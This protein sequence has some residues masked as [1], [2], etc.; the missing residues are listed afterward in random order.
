MERSEIVAAASLLADAYRLGQRLDALPQ[1]CQPTSVAEAHAIQD[2][3][4]GLLDEEVV[5]WKVAGTSADEVMRGALFASRVRPSPADFSAESVPLMGVE[6]EVAFRFRR[7]FPARA[8]GYRREE[9]AEGVDAFAAIEVVDTRFS[10]YSGTPPLHRL[11]DFMSNGG[12]VYGEPCPDWRLLDL[13]TIPVT[14][15]ADNVT[16]V[17]SNGGHKD[18]DPLLPAVALVNAFARGPGARAGQVVTT[19]T[20]TGL[21]YGAPGSVIR[22]AFDGL[23]SA[24]VHFH[25]IQSAGDR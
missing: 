13:A 11:C 5:G 21:H 2:V 7:D 3:L 23:G 6:A 4:V 12:L 10:S 9:V 17:Q 22:A 15:D 24:S 8:G 16:L 1:E 20:F 25:R 18:R 14:L 19:G